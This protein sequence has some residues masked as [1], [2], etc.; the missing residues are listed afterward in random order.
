[1]NAQT[2][3]TRIS[4]F[5]LAIVVL[6]LVLLLLVA[7]HR[8]LASTLPDNRAYEMV[9]PP[10]NAN[11]DV[12]VPSAS[13][14]N[15]FAP[16]EGVYTKRPFQASID[17]NMVTYIAD[18]ISGG[19][20]SGL[21]LGDSY[22]ASRSAGGGWAQVNL[23][24]FGFS[25]A[26]Y[27]AFSSD[28]S[29]GVLASGD[30]AF[31]ELPALPGT[32]A[33]G[34]GYDVL[35]TRDSSN[36][37]YHQFFTSKPPNR[38]A[39]EFEAYGVLKPTFEPEELAFA[40]ASTDFTRLFFEANDA[41]EG[42]GASDG[43]R[44][45]NNL[46]E[47]VDGRLDLVNV[48]PDGTSEANATFGAPGLGV[49]LNDSGPD[50]GNVISSD[51]SRAFWTGLNTNDLYVTEDVGMPGQKSV[52]I[53]ASLVR[54]L[55]GGG[56]FWTA[57]RD[58]S[59]V[60]FTDSEAADLTGDM[61]AGSGTNLYEYEPASTA[62]QS[63]ALKDL[64]PGAEADV[65]GVVGASENGEYVYFIATGVL[66]A[67]ENAQHQK[68]TSSGDNLYLVRHD[69]SPLFITTLSSGD[70]NET[71]PFRNGG[72][73][74]RFG[75]WQPGVGYR[76]AE[77]APDG[78][79]IVFMSKESLTGYPN[80]VLGKK[81]EE[82][83]VYE[84]DDNRLSCVSCNPDGVPP[85]SNMMTNASL[86]VGA[87]VPVSWSNTELPRWISAN[88]ERVFFDS[89]EPLVPQDTND[90]QDVY[91]WEREGEGSCTQSTGCV[92]LLS[93][94]V[95]ESASW[96]EGTSEN[97]DD[98]FIDT[99]AKLTLED[100]NE[101][102]DLYDVRVDGVESVL[103]PSCTGTGCQG[104]PA[105]PPTFATPPSVT[106][107]G[108]G[109]FPPPTPVPVVKAKVKTLTRTQKLARA[110]KACRGKQNKVKR[111]SCEAQARRRY[112]MSVKSKKAS[113][114]GSGGGR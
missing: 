102:F 72:G 71:Q 28:L 67:N 75:D 101:N 35:Y 39:Q 94:G 19:A 107:E 59:R 64:T 90:R 104:L 86:W 74:P 17:G 69:G 7:T 49:A 37:S 55:G 10:E 18:P 83:Y 54:G 65:E 30:G 111:A 13:A 100:Q 113:V 77:V 82:V 80:E 21:S 44:E 32:E 106:F 23:Q 63:G 85:E 79:G 6:V 105:P 93:G 47:S 25:D 41:M 98:V 14:G 70:Y 81:I 53:D 57:S 5:T 46:Y 38:S 84:A 66:S 11:A 26:A 9:T 88:G 109:N 78:A 15:A 114:H 33:P 29:A 61:L 16:G 45:E 31:P 62:G 24:P 58:G 89:E 108:V 76:T 50:F 20:R 92:Y 87:F 40:G 60:F 34:E 22:M 103:P 3:L 43:G 112:G 56:R 2:R 97:G 99:R 12:Y 91:E 48:L 52:Q 4:G 1:M 110:L 96:L 51:G 42:T 68:A 95:S 36:G 73:G 8:A 27:Q